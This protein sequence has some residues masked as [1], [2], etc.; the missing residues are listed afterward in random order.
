MKTIMFEMSEEQFARLTRA[1]EFRYA[2]LSELLK[3]RLIDLLEDP[4][5]PFDPRWQLRWE[6]E[7]EFLRRIA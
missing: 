5:D 4:I 2:T 7:A 6:R 1:A 3:A